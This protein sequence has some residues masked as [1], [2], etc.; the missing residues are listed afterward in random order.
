MGKQ[1]KLTEGNVR[2]S[3][4]FFKNGKMEIDFVTNEDA[5]IFA[6]DYLGYVERETK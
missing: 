2:K 5:T 1:I 6:K 3:I 4:K